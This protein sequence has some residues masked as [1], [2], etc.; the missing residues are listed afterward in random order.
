MESLSSSE[1]AGKKR[2]SAQV[3]YG[4][5]EKSK[6]VRVQHSTSGDDLDTKPSPKIESHKSHKE[7]ARRNNNISSVDRTLV[8]ITRKTTTTSTTPEK[9]EHVSLLPRVWDLESALL[10]LTQSPIV[11]TDGGEKEFLSKKQSNNV[12]WVSFRVGHAGDVSTIANWYRQ[13][14]LLDMPE[15]EF[16]EVKR[17]TEDGDDDDESKE[18]ET[19]PSSMLEV[20][21]AEG[22]GDED[23]PPAVHALIVQVHQEQKDREEEDD[24]ETKIMTTIG[25]VVLLTIGWEGECERVL[26]IPWIHFDT[27]NLPQPTV[28][29]LERRTWLRITTL[30]QMISCE[31]IHIDEKFTR[32]TNLHGEPNECP[33][34]CAE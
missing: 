28:R 10:Y 1:E 16:L 7:E 17:T 3:E 20:W 34:P 19:S 26:H 30:S 11:E 25:G 5:E 32:F 4:S 24:D 6:K 33:S 14:I 2:D 13:S 18:E 23:N 31:A 22:L 21:L 27:H 29:L 12:P 15:P 9:N 8:G